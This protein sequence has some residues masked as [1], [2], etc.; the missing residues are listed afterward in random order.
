[1]SFPS[2]SVGEV[3]TASDMNAV[4]LWHLNTTSFSGATQVDFTNVFTAA[5][6]SYKIVFHQWQ[7]TVGENH[8]LRLRNSGGVIS[9]TDYMT[10][11]NEQSSTTLSGVLV[12]GGFSTTFFPTFIVGTSF[13]A[14]AQVTGYLDVMRPNQSAFTMINGQFSRV[15][16]S[17][18]WNVVTAGF[19]RQTT[20]CTG[21][22]LIRNSTATMTGKVSVYGY[23]NT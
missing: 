7:A 11:R 21:F 9:T 16:G 12:G 13:D 20:V 23:R 22:S 10:N 15:D 14:N 6:D 19:Y 2:F 3:L 17:G 5:Y 8:F 1:M 18:G 4:G